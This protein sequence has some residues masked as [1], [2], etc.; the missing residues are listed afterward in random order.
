M[1]TFSKTTFG[2]VKVYKI[3]IVD[4]EVEV[5]RS[6]DGGDFVVVGYY[7]MSELDAG[8]KNLIDNGYT[9]IIETTK[10]TKT[11]TNT[12]KT[13]KE[14][15]KRDAVKSICMRTGKQSWTVDINGHNFTVVN[16]QFRGPWVDVSD[17]TI[18]RTRKELINCIM[19]YYSVEQ[20]EAILG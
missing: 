8:V 17:P 12:T 6:I 7:A 5:S 2:Q 14:L 4:G 3:A 15:I 1:R 9:E 19:H 11:M 18:R 10:N 20:L 13:M 16:G